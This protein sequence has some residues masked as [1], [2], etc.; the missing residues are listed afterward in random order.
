MLDNQAIPTNRIGSGAIAE[1]PI[2]WD[3]AYPGSELTINLE[4]K[5]TFELSPTKGAGRGR[6]IVLAQKAPWLVEQPTR[7]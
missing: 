3:I 6:L 2:N 1:S 5:E 7:S 4:R